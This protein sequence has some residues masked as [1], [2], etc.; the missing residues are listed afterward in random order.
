MCIGSTKLEQVE[1]HKYRSAIE[2]HQGT[3]QEEIVENTEAAAALSK[4]SA[5]SVFSEE[6]NAGICKKGNIQ[7]GGYISPDVWF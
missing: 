4:Q 5:Q 6:R 2:N 1:K 3:I 7:E